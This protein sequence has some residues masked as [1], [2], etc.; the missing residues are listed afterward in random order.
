MKLFVLLSYNEALSPLYVVS[1]VF[2]QSLENNKEEA[3]FSYYFSAPVVI[4]S[5]YEPSSTFLLPFPHMNVKMLKV[6]NKLIVSEDALIQGS[7]SC[8]LTTK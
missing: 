6:N 8:D 5:I 2:G 1:T 4:S 7:Q 3:F